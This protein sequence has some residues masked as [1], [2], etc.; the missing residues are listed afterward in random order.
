MSGLT[1]RP[2]Q[3]HPVRFQETNYYFLSC[4]TLLCEW[5]SDAS[6]VALRSRADSLAPRYTWT[7][8]IF[9]RYKLKTVWEALLAQYLGKSS[10]MQRRIKF[11]GPDL[12]SLTHSKTQKF[13]WQS[14]HW[15]KFPAI[16]SLDYEL[17]VFFNP[18]MGQKI[19]FNSPISTSS[20]QC[21]LRIKSCFPNNNIHSLSFCKWDFF[22]CVVFSKK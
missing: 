2:D 22:F 11:S 16:E 18:T 7:S 4:V 15:I 6:L 12:H 3:L 9:K 14:A 13:G 1:K 21:I 20:K 10:L 17:Q 5:I 19:N 8:I